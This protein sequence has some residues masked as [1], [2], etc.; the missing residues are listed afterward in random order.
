VS[1]VLRL[2]VWR[3][4]LDN[5]TL[6]MDQRSPGEEDPGRDLACDGGL[7]M[8]A[9][10]YARLGVDPGAERSEIEAA[11]KRLQ[12]TWSMGTRNPKTRHTNQLFLDEIPA[13]R[14]ALLGDP[15]S[16]AAYDAELAVVQIAERDAR[17]DEL[18]KRAKLRAAKGGLS[19]SDRAIL[20]DEAARLGLSDDDLT[21]VTKNIP[22]LVEAASVNGDGADDHDPPGDVLDPSTRRQIRVVLDH[23]G[24]RD[25][26]DALG[27]SRDAPKTYIDSRADEER[28][29]WMKKAQV[30]AEKTAW[31]E[32]ITHGQSHLSSPKA[33][34]RY[35]R[36]LAQEAE[37][38]FDGLAVFALKGLTGLDPGTRT[39]LIDEAAALGISSERAD[40]LIGRICRRSGV[41]LE[42]G[43]AAPLAGMQSAA[44]LGHSNGAARFSILRCRQCA[45]VTEMSPVARKS[46]TARCRHCGASLKWHCPICKRNA[47][48]DER[49]CECGFRQALREPVVRHF[50][51]AQQ[52]FRN[53][54]LEGALEHLAKVQAFAPN[55][56]GAR[57]G[58]SKIRQRQADIARVQLGYET[59]RAG[60]RLVSARG[61][62]EAW[63]KLVDPETPELNAAFSEV[64]AQLRRA[65][66]LAARARKVERTEP[67]TAREL[68]RQSLAI[69]ADLPDALTGLKRTPPD[70]PTAL[71][72]QVYG[73]RIRL[74]WT[75]PSPDGLG[76]LT[77]VVVRKRGGVLL[78]PADGTRVAEVSTS[79]Y[80]DMHVTPGDTAGYAVLSKRAGVESV[81]AISLGPFVY[82]ADVKDVRVEVRHQEVE[83]GWTLPRGVSDVRVIR[84]QGG[85]PRNPRD[86]DRIAA[87]LD[88]V[89]DRN[90]DADEAYHYGIYAVYAMSDGRLFPSPGVVVSA[91]AQ[92][93]VSALEAPRL[94]VESDGRVR[95]DWIEPVRGSVKIL[96]MT[97]PLPLA[98]GSRLTAAEVDALAGRWIEPAAPDR[99]YDAEPPAEGHCYYVPLT[100]WAGTYTVG[101]T[102][103][104]SRVPDPSELR[105]T[106]TGTGLGTGSG[107][108]RVA[109]RW[110]WAA[111]ASISLIVARQGTPAVGPSDPAAVRATVF[112]AD[113]DRQECWTLNLSPYRPVNQLELSP[114]PSQTGA[115]PTP[116]SASNDV[117]PW[118]IRVYSVI[119]LN[120]AT[121]V[122]PGLEPSA[123]TI[124]PGPNPEVTVSYV[125]K[126]PWLPGLPWSV[127]FRTEPPN[128]VVPCMVLVAHPRAV[129]L[130]AD[131]GQIVAHFPLSRDGAQ[132]P[133]RTPLSLAQH[134]I[135]VFPDPAVEPD[136][137]MPI[138]LRHPESG[139]ARV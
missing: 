55:L 5:T 134:G 65:E 90:L 7:T 92:P 79:E 23:L 18:Q 72:G 46:N 97:D 43:S 24:C 105:A 96:R 133:I 139:T 40:Q 16:R 61:A 2:D 107:A 32:I 101:H 87:A 108:T 118:H 83:L 12:P 117:G 11:L 27:V 121:A 103:A 14:K 62:V 54:D 29:R 15:A 49:R 47:W 4:L 52:A 9:D 114:S 138:R 119:E 84:K 44:A 136:S 120:G 28:Q 102:S 66:L 8:V 6:M 33:R 64:A 130:S 94:L 135:R 26:Y 115:N 126:R 39:A 82:L 129:P 67:A 95:I 36:T 93:P 3:R 63:S 128:S 78:H 104:L 22:M 125:L 57:N 77:F 74:S 85:P 41:A 25:L 110:R 112:R 91:R 21:R 76:P 116:Q 127:T 124:L 89:L 131:D 98:A 73:D 13:L 69:A 137:L 100:V 86:G 81:S 58:I 75:P 99:A 19:A 37:E 71:E 45:G 1:L 10:Y 111:E 31:L 80:D 50:E 68:Y 35:D 56:A 38:T 70:A 106:R 53:F 48:V 122:S 59:A 109:L 17:L 123:A 34:A 88:H 113:Y 60:G 20:A 132:F 30:T 51:A 42:Q